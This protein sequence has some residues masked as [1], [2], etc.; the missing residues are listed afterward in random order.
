[1]TDVFDQNTETKT[2]VAPP[3]GS[4]PF[5]DKLK[6]IVNDKGEPKYKDTQSALDALV[7]S[8]E[9]IKRLEAEKA[10]EKVL[11]DNAVAEKARADALEEIVQRFSNNSQTPSRVETTTKE[12]AY[13]ETAIVKTLET[14][15][16]NKEAQTNAQKNTQA[17]TDS[18]VAKFGDVEKTKAAVAAKA[19]ELGMT[20]QELGA[21]S[22]KN[23]KA[24]L[25]W[26]GVDAPTNTSQSVVPSQTSLQRPN[27]TGELKRPELSLISGPGAT[28]KARKQFMADVKAEVYKRHNV[29][30]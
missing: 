29:T 11:I 19:K 22:S 1:M 8:Q 9:H 17:V 7:A 21:L 24:V 5:A 28:D 15:L 10:A 23:P 4:D 2:Q 6:A 18:L 26:F 12:T 30:T 13:D 3:L 27:D 20:S 16:A 14:L 25:A